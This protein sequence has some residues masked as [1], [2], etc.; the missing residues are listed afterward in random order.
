MLKHKLFC[1]VFILKL[2]N[3]NKK[4]KIKFNNGFDT[5]E[6]IEIAKKHLASRAEDLEFFSKCTNEDEETF[7]SYL[8]YN[9]S[10]FTTV[11]ELEQMIQLHKTIGSF[12]DYGLSF[13]FVD[14]EK[15][16][17]GFYRYQFSYGGPS[18]ELRI[19]EDGNIVFVYLD[20][21]SGIGFDVTG[22][23]WAE[24]VRDWFEDVGSINWDSL[25]PEQR[26]ADEDLNT[27]TAYV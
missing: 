6:K 1:M 27:K 5:P 19:Y 2:L 4:M 14:A 26:F 21:F 9:M 13:D 17:P 8:E 24:W 23:D 12:Y 22:E 15:G 11:E 25:D 3:N 20:W 10:D 18:E 7:L 16:E